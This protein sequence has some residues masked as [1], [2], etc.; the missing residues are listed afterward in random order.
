MQHCCASAAQLYCC[1]VEKEAELRFT[2]TVGAMQHICT[3]CEGE[4][5]CWCLADDGWET[6]GKKRGSAKIGDQNHSSAFLGEYTPV[7]PAPTA[8]AARSAPAAPSAAA[9]AAATPAP[10]YPPSMRPDV[11]MPPT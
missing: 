11:L 2:S 4:I 9:P 1:L 5:S 6:V 8:A 3:L 7:A 10:R